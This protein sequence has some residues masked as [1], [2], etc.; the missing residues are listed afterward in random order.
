MTR[1]IVLFKFKEETGQDKIMELDRHFRSLPASID[2]LTSLEGGE[3]DSPENLAGGFTHGYL[4][5]F[6]SEQDRDA[7]LPHPEH[8]SFVGELKEAIEDV[9]VFDYSV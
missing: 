6:S 7:Y 2:V 4:L 9:L 1:H 3:N 8:Q 5:T